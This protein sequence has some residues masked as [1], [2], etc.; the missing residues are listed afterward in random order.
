M[1]PNSLSYNFISKYPDVIEITSN[2]WKKNCT[3]KKFVATVT[4]KNV[5][6]SVFY[7]LTHIDPHVP[8]QNMVLQNSDFF[9]FG[10]GRVYSRKE[11]H[12]CDFSEKGQKKGKIFENLGQNVQNLKIFW[13][14]AASFV[15]LKQLK[16]ME[17]F[18]EKE[19][20]KSPKSLQ[21]KTNLIN[22]LDKD[23]LKQ[24]CHWSVILVILVNTFC[25]SQTF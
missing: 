22:N 25:V 16:G 14:R 2:L 4:I 10:G 11:D 3:V 21:N 5:V 7:M 17:G 18:L 1:I 20:L 12:A 6:V 13:K 15:Q 8:K 19:D 24:I 9:F 23:C